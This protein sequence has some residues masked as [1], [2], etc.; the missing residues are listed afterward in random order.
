MNKKKST[1]NAWNL[2]VNDIKIDQIDELKMNVAINDR[3]FLLLKII[4]T[5]LIIFENHFRLILNLV[6]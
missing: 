6:T 3:F 5:F 1:K 4:L 2:Q